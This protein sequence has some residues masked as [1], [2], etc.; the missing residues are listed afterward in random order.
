MELESFEATSN[1][2]NIA[3]QSPRNKPK[4]TRHSRALTAERKKL[5]GHQSKSWRCTRSKRTIRQRLFRSD[6]RCLRTSK[7]SYLNF[8]EQI[9]ISS[10]GQLQK[11]KASRLRSSSTISM[12]TPN[13]NRFDKKGGTSPL[14]DNELSTK[15]WR[16]FW[17]PNS[18]RKCTT[19]TSRLM[20]W[21]S[22]KQVANGAFVSTTPT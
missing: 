4:N 13:L 16:N 9:W 15:K 1:L 17:Q 3:F 18:S 20:W 22:K 21:W 2:Q 14:K 6:P 7:R 5:G 10:H 19:Q 8:L 12:S 11:C